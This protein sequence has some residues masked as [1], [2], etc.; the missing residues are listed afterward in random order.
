MGSLQN[1]LDM[2]LEQNGGRI[3]Y[4]HEDST[5]RRLAAQSGNAGFILPEFRK[6]QLFPFVSKNGA[7]PRKT[8]SMGEGCDKRYYFEARRIS[9][10]K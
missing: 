10:D 8:F 9:V 6:E 5:V 3:D 7:L 2:F 1:A 4:V